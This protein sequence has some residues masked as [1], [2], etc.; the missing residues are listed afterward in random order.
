MKNT[1]EGSLNTQ[2]KFRVFLAE[3]QPDGQL[4][5]TKNVGVAYM[6]EGQ[7][8]ISLRLWMFNNE[9][10]YLI[11]CKND[12]NRC[13]IMTRAPKRNPLGRSKYFWNIVGNGKLNSAFGFM[14]LEFDILD[15]RIF[16]ALNPEASS[17]ASGLPEP[18]S[19]G[20]VA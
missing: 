4:R 11:P 5:R 1:L 7:S 15:K 10:F 18:I 12:S 19:F 3:L 13:L 9:R 6:K 2:L 20:E 14:V 16:V 17:I 8:T